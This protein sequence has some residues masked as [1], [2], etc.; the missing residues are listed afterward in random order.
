MMPIR[1]GE[2]FIIIDYGKNTRLVVVGL[3]VV[4]GTLLSAFP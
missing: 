4:P 1:I 3:D 2:H